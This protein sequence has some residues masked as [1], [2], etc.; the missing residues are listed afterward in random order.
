M[1]LARQASTPITRGEPVSPEDV[2]SGATVGR[3]P[4][5]PSELGSRPPLLALEAETVN[6]GIELLSDTGGARPSVF[7][8]SA[9]LTDSAQ[10]QA[11]TFILHLIRAPAR[12]GI[13]QVVA[14]SAIT[15]LREVRKRVERLPVPTISPG[16]GGFIGLTWG[17]RGH[18]VNTEIYP[19]G[20]VENFWEDPATGELGFEEATYGHV[21]TASLIA[22]LRKTV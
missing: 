7:S 5:A 13:T 10:V 19:D 14:F 17:T 9:I 12:G 4:E 22:A 16:P 2:E 1:N 20:H 15:L 18:H 6:K 21:P 11:E 8:L 3:A